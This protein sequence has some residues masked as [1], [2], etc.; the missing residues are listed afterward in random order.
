MHGWQG[1]Y[2][3]IRLIYSQK[4]AFNAIEETAALLERALLNSKVINSIEQNAKHRYETEKQKYEEW[5]LKEL[6]QLY[7]NKMKDEDDDDSDWGEPD[8]MDID[9]IARKLGKF[10]I[11]ET[12]LKAQKLLTDELIWLGHEPNKNFSFEKY[13]AHMYNRYEKNLQ[14][15]VYD[16]EMESFGNV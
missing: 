8:N 1:Y 6:P 12:Y 15:C 11:P 7:K 3:R 2:R 14:Q 9:N 5:K 13:A 16:D 4:N 10:V